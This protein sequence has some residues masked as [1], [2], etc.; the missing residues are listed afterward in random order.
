MVSCGGGGGAGIVTPS[1]EIRIPGVGPNGIFDA[2]IATDGGGTLWMSYSEVRFSPFSNKLLNVR[3]RLAASGDAG[4][5]WTDAGILTD[6]TEF[7]VPDP[8]GGSAW[9]IV[10]QQEVSRIEYDAADTDAGR[11]WKLLWHRYTDSYNPNTDTRAPLYQNGWIALK[12][13][14][15]PGGLATAGERRLFTGTWYNA[16]DNGPSE[17]PLDSL[18]PALSDCATFTEPGILAVSSGMYVALYCAPDPNIANSMG[19]IVLLQCTHTAGAA[20]ASCNYLGNLLVNNEAAAHGAYNG[21]S[22]PDLVHAGTRD[23]L[24]VTPT[25]NNG[26]RGCLVFEIADLATASLVRDAQNKAVAV[27]SL[28]NSHGGG[29]FGACGY[30]PA[31][32]ASGIIDSS[33]H[34]SWNPQFRIFAS[35]NNLP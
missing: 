29:H 18:V 35:K 3:T 16:T 21:F 30:H 17:Y 22:A 9:N 8:G 6:F 12:T 14:A 20:F 23:Y 2:A 25:S 5:N 1:N 34:T 31:A 26:Y 24:I 15:T 33:H 27:K 19:K 4:A 13:A 7:T 10:W 32:T 28:A 11:R